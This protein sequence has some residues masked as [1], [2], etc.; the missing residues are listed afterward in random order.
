MLF[1]TFPAVKAW[2][3]HV[4]NLPAWSRMCDIK[5]IEQFD[6]KVR[7]F[8]KIKRQPEITFYYHPVSPPARMV[9][10]FLHELN[11]KVLQNNNNDH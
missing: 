3:E 4:K 8:W 1:L 6:N 10:F 7:K 9:E 2:F 5:E 11:G